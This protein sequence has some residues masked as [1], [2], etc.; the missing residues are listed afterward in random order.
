MKTV[1]VF[2]CFDIL[3]PGHLWFLQQAKKYGEMLVVVLARDIQIARIKGHAPHMEEKDRL[4]LVKALKLVDNAYLG[5][6]AYRYERLVKKIKPDTIVLGYD[7]KE[8]IE[9][10]QE[11]IGD[12]IHI[13]RLKAYKPKK[14][15]SSLMY[16]RH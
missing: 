11:K 2:G 7:Q 15:K 12:N 1:L 14:Y 5:D 10:I 8:T 6:T 4:V 9:E 16:A 13:V 3:H